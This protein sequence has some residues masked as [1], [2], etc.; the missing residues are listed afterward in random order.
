MTRQYDERADLKAAHDSFMACTCVGTLTYLDPGSGVLAE[1]CRV[2]RPGGLV[3]FTHRTDKLEQ[4]RPVQA[5]MC[6]A[7]TWEAVEI[8]EAMDYLP[9]HPEYGPQGIQMVL[10]VYRVC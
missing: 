4:W 7:K 5:R 10:H 3:C 9:N 6:D 8:T 1:F 2:V